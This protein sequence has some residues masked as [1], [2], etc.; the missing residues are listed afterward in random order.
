VLDAYRRGASGVVPWQTIDRDGSALAKA[1]P[2][3]LF[4]FEAAGDADGV[5]VHPTIRLKAFR[6]A[7][8]LVAYLELARARNGWTRAELEDFL[9][10]HA[11]AAEDSPRTGPEDEAP[12]ARYARASPESFRRLR[13]AAARAIESAPRAHTSQSVSPSRGGAHSP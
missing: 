3:G 5:R 12:T 13:E 6:E 8:Q 4:V 7:E 11:P 2:L 1:D 10:A 9:D